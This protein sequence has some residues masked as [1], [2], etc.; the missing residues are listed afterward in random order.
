MT[1]R[2]LW[3]LALGVGSVAVQPAHALFNDRLFDHDF[4]APTDL[5]AND[6]EAARFLT[7]ATF[8]PTTADIALVRQIGYSRWIK[9][10]F[11]APISWTRPHM[12]VLHAAMQ[13]ATPQQSVGHNQRLDR[14]FHTAVTA[15]DQLRQ[16]MAF[17]LSQ[18]MV[19]SDQNGTLAG[20]PIQ[21]S[22]YQDLLA[23]FGLD[24]YRNLLQHVTLDPSMGKYLSHFRNRRA[25]GTSQPDENYAREVMQLFTIGL[26]ERNLDFSPILVGGQP[27]PTYDQDDISNLARVFTGFNYA[28]TTS[29]TQGASGANLYLSMTCIQSWHDIDAKQIFTPAIPIAANQQCIPEVTYVLDVLSLHDNVAPFVA[30]QLIQRFTS[31]TPSAAY[32]QRVAQK[33]NDNGWGERADLGA[34]IMQILLDPE[35]RAAPGPNSGKPREPLLKLTA[36]WRAWN[37]RLPNPDA[38]GNIP[39]GMTNPTGTYGQR[40]LGADSVFNFYQPD[41]SQPGVVAGAGLY[42]PEFQ[43]LNESTI[44][45]SGNNFYTN[46]LNGYIGMNNAPTNRPLLDLSP[47]IAFGKNYTGMVDEANR[48]MLNGSMS[49]TMREALVDMAENMDSSNTTAQKAASIVY[50]VALSPEYAVQ[51]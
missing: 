30:R 20:E 34:V 48:R 2:W 7:Q 5:P 22:H 27:V 45:S 11:H 24:S 36:M 4:E 10:Q 19:I 17:A 41:Y 18:I 49:A 14:W 44:T 12:E 23:L 28:G 35:A 38:F 6:A 33:Y 21:V 39:M 37:A 46:S 9:Q 40:P 26:V 3:V 13:A 16:R 42:S 50:L 51:R 25:N 29:I 1:K 43:I 47:L 8:G 15:P 31:S 32:I